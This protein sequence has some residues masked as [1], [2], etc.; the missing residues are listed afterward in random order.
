M[1][2]S[3][4]TTF[5]NLI[6]PG[7][8]WQYS[9]ESNASGLATN[10]VLMLVGEADAGPDFSL[11]EDLNANQFGPTQL[12]DV[13]AK[14]KTGT[15]VDVFAA[16]CAPANDVNIQGSFN[17]CILVKTNVSGK[18]SGPLVKFDSSNYSTLKDKS[19]GK[20][21]NLINYTVTAKTEEVVP[22]TG[23]FAALLPIASTNINLRINGGAANA[24]TQAALGT[25]ATLVSNLNGISGIVATGG[26]AGGIVAGP[27]SGTLALT[28]L[29]G[30][31]VQIDCS[32][33][34]VGTL[35]VAG[36]TLYIPSTSPLA[37]STTN[38]GSYIVT[39]SSASQILAI[40]LR[41]VTGA[42]D[43]LTAPANKAAIAIAAATDLQCWTA[44]EVALD[45]SIDPIAGRGKTL[46]I[47]ELTS[48]SGL[49][50]DMAY[51]LNGSTPTVVTWLS[52]ASAVNVITSAAEYKA[53]LNVARQLDNISEDIY[54]GG[55][56]ALKIGYTG[57][58]ASLVNDGETLTIT[59][60]GGSGT[61]P[62]AITLA[63]FPTI[64]DLATYI[65][66]L[67]GFVCTPGTAVIGSKPATALDQGTFT[68]CTQFGAYAGRIKMDAYSFFNTLTQNGILTEMEEAAASG[69]PAP[70]ALAYLSG[71]TKGATTNTSITG[72]IDA[73]EIT[74]GNFLI[75]LFSRDASEDIEDGLTDTASTYT[76][77]TIHTYSRAH[78]LKMSAPKRRRPR[79]AFLSIDTTFSAAKTAAANMANFR[80]VMPFQ[81]MKDLAV[82]NGTIRQFQSYLSAAKAAAMQAAGLYKSIV[83]K[84]IA[85]NGVLQKAGDFK[86]QN[87]DQMEEALL[88]G[89]LPIQLEED[90]S[91]TWVSDQTTYGKDNNFV[92][93]SIEAVYVSDVVSAT[94]GQRLDKAYTGQSLADVSASMAKS[95][96]EKILDDMFDIKLIA[97]SSDA[98]KG[99][100]DITIKITGPSME[101]SAN[102]K[103]STCIYFIPINVIVSQI[104]QS[105]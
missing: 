15:L 85:C 48:A 41:D 87:L 50:S 73:L 97:A 12:S 68:F 56:I 17:K 28:V 33:P 76:I 100:K 78:V 86:D 9:V 84:G 93:N 88:A 42:H 60:T 70:S 105:A 22:T 96:V 32:V 38:A 81:D 35:P 55:D 19:Y 103:V 18:A 54:A 26:V 5:G 4:Q 90:G 44:V 77:D 34:F 11:E 53:N 67:T 2:Q 58:T 64:A 23:K 95:T 82:S 6:A 45:S 20:L 14:Y 62:D 89:L 21:G 36:D 8:Y 52:K 61:S 79:Q 91:I 30:N 25:P 43:A 13:K 102:I 24:I 94:L 3:K 104:T 80:C 29:S 40:K 1:A 10:G 16:I 65:N 7:A 63:D 98:P 83:K 99:Y 69:L 74:R 51:V 47:N 75:P 37:A 46:E 39:G 49:L 57:T 72:A 92:Y 31:S 101:V 66:S 27:L 59:V 71:G